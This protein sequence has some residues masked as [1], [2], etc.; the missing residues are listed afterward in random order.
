MKQDARYQVE[1]RDVAPGL[2]IPAL[3]GNSISHFG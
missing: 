1:L 3:T 2:W